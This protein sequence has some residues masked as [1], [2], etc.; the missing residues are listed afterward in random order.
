MA[1]VQ[2]GI[3]ISGTIGNATFYQMFGRTYVRKKSSLTRKRVLKSKA[4]EKTRKCAR[5]LGLA[6]KIGSVIYK[7]LPLDIRKDRWLYRAI[8]G[9]A[10]SLLYEGKEYQEVKELLWEKYITDTGAIP[11][12]DKTIEEGSWNNHRS[13]KETNIK[14][15]SVFQERWQKQGMLYYWFKRAWKKRGKFN[16]YTFQEVLNNAVRQRTWTLR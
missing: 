5:D 15:R 1:R 3:P 14:I 11:E 10:A 12:N 16:P 8:T 13:T 4:F 6:A 2:S 9:E 7:A